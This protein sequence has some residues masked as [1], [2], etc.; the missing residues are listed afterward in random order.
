MGKT[1][2]IFPGQGSQTVGMGKD[3]YDTSPA[4]KQVFDAADEALRMSLS[5][6]CFNGPKDELT[7]TVNAQPALLVMSMA[8][9]A[10]LKEEAPNAFAAPS[11]M[12]GHSLGEYSALT[13]ADSLSF[14]DAVRLARE[15][16]RLM[17]EAG[18]E[19]PG[20]M[21]SIIA[22]S[23]EEVEK[24]CKE[25][26]T[27]IA[28][29]NCPGQI[30]ISGGKEEVKKAMKLAKERGARMAIPLQVSGAFHSPLM[31]SASDS[32]R[33]MI[34][35]TNISSPAVPVVGNTKAQLM[36]TKD[37]VKTELEE[38][39]CNSVQWEASVRF[40]LD[41][42]VDTFIE[43]GA[44]KVLSGLLRRIDPKAKAINIGSIDNIKSLLS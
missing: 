32:L 12:A 18:L 30:A 4:A 13:A 6:L 25:T 37:D 38:Q 9:L 28:N 1:A 42:G 35:K 36:T 39:V 20:S 43:L 27:Y 23:K 40:M 11:Y 15:R 19:H 8:S 14:V 16:G 21:A 41:Q 22:M 3:L 24:V 31:Q 5:Q 26:G 2:Y 17:Y 10:A 29:Y 34:E 44:G 33:P 7:K